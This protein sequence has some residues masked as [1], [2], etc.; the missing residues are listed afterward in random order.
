MML[1]TSPRLSEPCSS[2]D[3][4]SGRKRRVYYCTTFVLDSASIAPTKGGD[5]GLFFLAA[6]GHVPAKPPAL[7]LPK[8]VMLAFFSQP[9]GGMFPR[10]CQ[11]CPYQ[12]GVML[13]VSIY[14]YQGGAGIKNACRSLFVLGHR[15]C[16]HFDN[17]GLG[18][19][20]VPK[21]K[22]PRGHNIARPPLLPRARIVANVCWSARA[23]RTKK[24]T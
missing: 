13:A 11:H 7:P 8:G 24:K 17:F 16:F 5:A 10:K 3:R 23:H 18:I 21:Q 6:R 22:W 15:G 19:P 12:R 1:N 4:P 14:P 20:N 2:L 9:P